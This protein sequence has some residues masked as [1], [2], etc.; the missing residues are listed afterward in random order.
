[1][2]DG[3][4]NINTAKGY[5]T[6]NVLTGNGAIPLEGAIVTISSR[7]GTV[8]DGISGDILPGDA[9]ITVRTNNSGS[10]PRL[11]LP[12]PSAALS[13]SPTDVVPFARYDISVVLEGY[14]RQYFFGAP[15]F[16]GI[17]SIQPVLMKPLPENANES[18]YS[19]YDN[20]TF[21]NEEPDL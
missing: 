6:V 2:N 17:T 7:D 4:A 14:E 5:L 15:V 13:M 3:S 10:T 1:M 21:E 8:L 11:V 12:V 9:F 18:N 20:R 19:A 16:D